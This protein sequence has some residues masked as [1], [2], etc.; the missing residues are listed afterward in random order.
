MENNEEESDRPIRKDKNKINSLGPY[1]MTQQISTGPLR[2]GG[3][4]TSYQHRDLHMYR[5]I[6]HHTEIIYKQTL[7]TVFLCCATYIS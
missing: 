1:K 4:V 3:N 2:R 5:N 7:N 6:R